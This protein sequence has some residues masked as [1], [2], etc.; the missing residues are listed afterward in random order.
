MRIPLPSTNWFNKTVMNLPH[1]MRVS[2]AGCLLIMLTA[3]KISAAV[4][5]PD[6]VVICILENHSY[7][8]IVG[9]ADAPYI[10]SLLPQSAHLMEYYA[11][12]HPSQP[13]YIMMFS[14][15]NQG[16]TTDNLPT[17]T[18]WTT[19]NLGA[20]LINTGYTFTGYSEDL[21]TLGSTVASSGAYARKHCPW[22]NWQGS[23][24]NQIPSTCSMSMDNFPT[25]FTHLPDVAFVIP[26]QNNDMHNGSDPVKIQVGDSW[27]QH[28]LKGY[29]DWAM[30]HNSLF[31]LTFD[32]D[33]FSSVNHIP[34]L[35]M[36][37][38]VQPGS[39]YLNGYTHYDL[40]RTVE[41]MFTLPHAGNAATAHSIE[42]IWMQPTQ[43]ADVAKAF[44]TSI[45]PNPV[46]D[47][48][49]ISID[50]KDYNRGS[51][52]LVVYDVTGRRV[53]HEEIQLT[54][55]MNQVPFRKEQLPSGIFT[56][57]L[58]NEDRVFVSGKIVVQ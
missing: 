45:F 31:I 12:T 19:P 50:V 28:N 38:K 5:R 55:G 39:Y 40:L 58:E 43:V 22:V 33:N 57:A 37:E 51:V 8:Q 4:P 27:V 48:S 42:E 17:G 18:P 26:N 30:T 16:E 46:T 36:G 44:Q 47:D 34:C 52:S 56:Y 6:H 20:S 10:N 3:V 11:L 25:D 9:A 49:K 1:S 2:I 41:D 53:S 15:Q 35:F 14:G 13:N 7:N 24:Q 29:I 21:P 32:E 23:G 54:P